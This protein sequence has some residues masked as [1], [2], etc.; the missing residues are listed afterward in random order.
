M[1]EL[2]SKEDLYQALDRAAEDLFS[3][4]MILSGSRQEAAETAVLDTLFFALE[5]MMITRGFAA[6]QSF[7]H[8]EYREDLF[9]NI[10]TLI[11]QQGALIQAKSLD[12]SVLAVESQ[13]FYQ[14]A[15]QDRAA[16]FLRT[17]GKFSEEAIARIMGLSQEVI[18]A[19]ILKAR[20]FLLGKCLKLKNFEEEF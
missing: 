10:Y 6:D 19:H 20:E 8:L 7:T 17:R 13:R 1:S 14:L 12:P 9:R 2:V 18:M 3:F 5:R 4:A 15:F 16:I 11:R